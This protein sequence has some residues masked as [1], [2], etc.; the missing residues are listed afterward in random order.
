MDKNY[1]AQLYQ[2][3]AITNKGVLN[4][5]IRGWITIA[6]AVEIL[7]DDNA[8]DTVRA[9]KLME[10]SKTCNAVIVA[11][12]DV[13]VGDQSEGVHMEHFNLALEDQNNIN[14]LF[15]VVELGGTEFPYQ[16]DDGSCKVYSA[17][18]IAAIYIA[19]QT[20]ITTQTAYHNALKAYVNA[21]TESEEIATVQYGMELPEPFASELASKLAVAQTQ[22]E[23]ILQRLG[24]AA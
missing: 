18:E 11:G 20:L 4:A 5:I 3:K 7:G 19:A 24:E 13:P 21:L 6:D 16:A 17:N 15:R 14:N 23:A 9:A 8:M 22:M 2:D 12:V 10:I 1:I